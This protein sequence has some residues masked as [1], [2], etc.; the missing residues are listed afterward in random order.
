MQTLSHR[1]NQCPE[2]PST[3]ILFVETKGMWNTED[4]PEM[5]GS[6]DVYTPPKQRL[7]DGPQLEH[8]LAPYLDH[9][10]IVIS[11]WGALHAPLEAFRRQLPIDV[12]KRVIDSMFLPELTNSSWSEY[13]ST[14]VTRYDC[15]RL[16]LD[17]RRPRAGD[18]WIAIEQGAQLDAWPAREREHVIIGKLAQPQVLRRVLERLNAQLGTPGAANSI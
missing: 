1:T 2:S 11:D 7:M 5:Q 6:S 9:V 17:R 16:W 3:W 13:H 15:L 12:A 18:Q 10:E 4:V 8:A 14:V